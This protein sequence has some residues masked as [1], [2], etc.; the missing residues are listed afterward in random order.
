MG[1]RPADVSDSLVRA[2]EGGAGR[3]FHVYIGLFYQEKEGN[4]R[5][6]THR[7]APDRVVPAL[8]EALRLA[9]G[10][11]EKALGLIEQTLQKKRLI[12]G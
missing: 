11:I 6:T 12:H 1:F 7:I 9:D 4:Q 5:P 2:I 8:R 10:D 3:G